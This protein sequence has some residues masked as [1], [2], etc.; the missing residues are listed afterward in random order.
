MAE[1]AYTVKKSDRRTI[2]ICILPDGTVE[3]RCPRRMPLW[4]V[5]A[6]VIGKQGWIVKQLSTPREA[7]QKLTAQELKTLTAD[8]ARLIPLRVAHFASSM[9]VTYGTITIRHQ[10]TR[11]GSCSAKGNLNFNCLLMLAPPEVLDY[12]VVH[13]LCHRKALNHSAAFW[14]EVAKVMPGYGLHRKW[15]KNNGAGLVARLP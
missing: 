3:V 7:V 10:K 14:A 15:L 13:E 5:E 8:A 9:G 6:F 2:A 1:I 4:Q 12:V 11:W